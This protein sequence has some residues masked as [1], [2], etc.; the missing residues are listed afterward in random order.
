MNPMK[1]I[2]NYVAFVAIVLLIFVMALFT[3]GYVNLNEKI[4]RPVPVPSPDDVGIQLAS[5]TTI[6]CPSYLSYADQTRLEQGTGLAGVDFIY[7]ERQTGIDALTLMAIAAHESTWGSNFWAANYNNVMSWGISDVNPDRVKY[8]TKSLNV[9]VAAAGLK[10]LYLTQ[11]STYWG[12]EATLVGIN[13]YYASDKSWST[14]VLAIVKE[15]EG[16]LTEQQRMKRYC[17]KTGLFAAPVNWDYEHTVTG[18]ALYKTN[19][20][21]VT[22]GR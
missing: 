10:R 19:K 20:A 3:F 15:L 21:V 17:V 18:W 4:D 8:A 9:L 6:L 1:E 22:A 13:R 7:V 12:G 2:P 16:K 5:Q 14:G 11:G